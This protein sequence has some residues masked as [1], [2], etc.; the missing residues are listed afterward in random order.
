MLVMGVILKITSVRLSIPWRL[1][2]AIKAGSTAISTP[3]ASLAIFHC[4]PLE[5]FKS[6]PPYEVA[7]IA[8]LALNRSGN[9][10]AVIER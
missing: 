4:I 2:R 5:V 3:L 9:A 8:G 7:F 6:I 10:G 1:T